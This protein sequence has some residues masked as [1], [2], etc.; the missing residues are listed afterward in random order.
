MLVIQ[1]FEGDLPSDEVKALFLWVSPGK[2]IS[3]PSNLYQRFMSSHTQ[4]TSIKGT[5]PKGSKQIPCLHACQWFSINRSQLQR[6]QMLWVVCY[7]L[8]IVP[9]ASGIH[10]CLWDSLWTWLLSLFL[11]M[12]STCCW[13]CWLWKQHDD[14]FHLEP[15]I[16]AHIWRSNEKIF[17]C[18]QV[19]EVQ[20]Y[21]SLHFVLSVLS[22]QKKK[23]SPTPDSICFFLQL[24][25]VVVS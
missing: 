21:V 9:G 23:K 8:R 1:T 3:V 15:K 20:R 4:H 16:F 11:E 12:M 18:C 2:R 5:S 19:L 6:L 24:S 7:P 13:N 25:R 17:M 10:C 22:V 14:Y